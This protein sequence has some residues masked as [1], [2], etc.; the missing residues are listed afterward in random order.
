MVN[1]FNQAFISAIAFT[2]FERLEIKLEVHFGIWFFPFQILH[3]IIID[4]YFLSFETIVGHSSMLI[5][6]WCCF[7]CRVGI[8]IQNDL[9]F[10]AI[11]VFEILPLLYLSK[12]YFTNYIILPQQLPIWKNK[13]SIKECQLV[14]DMK[15]LLVVLDMC[16]S[17]VN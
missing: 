17:G 10:L 9:I 12:Y 13:W 5:C 3:P 14:I 11:H 4:I 16:C 6:I 7:G 15:T 1:W 8:Q 2:L